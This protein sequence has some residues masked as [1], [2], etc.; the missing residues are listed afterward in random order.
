MK[1]KNASAIDDVSIHCDGLVKRL[2]S[3]D[4]DV[5]NYSDES[6]YLMSLSANLTI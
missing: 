3:S 4:V 1:Q 2:K 6:P 5:L